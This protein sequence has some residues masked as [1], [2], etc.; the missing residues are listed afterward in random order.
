[1]GEGEGQ[2]NGDGGWV[3]APPRRARAWRGQR[4]HARLPCLSLTYIYAYISIYPCDISELLYNFAFSPSTTKEKM[5]F[6]SSSSLS[7]A[8]AAAA[9]SRTPNCPEPL[10]WGM[11]PLLRTYVRLFA[12][13]I[14]NRLAS[15]RGVKESYVLQPAGR[16]I[17]RVVVMG[18]IIAT[19]AK[20]KFI[21]YI[22]DDGTGWLTC[23]LWEKESMT[24]DPLQG[25]GW[26]RGRLNK[27]GKQRERTLLVYGDHAYAR[28]ELP[29]GTLVEVHGRLR[30]HCAPWN[31]WEG[32]K[33]E[34]EI[35]VDSLRPVEDCNEELWHWLECIRLWKECYSQPCPQIQAML[36]EQQEKQK[37]AQRQQWRQRHHW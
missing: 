35:S 10:V 30:S 9:S 18:H 36:Q 15:A 34:R 6:S 33:P 26:S 24:T 3:S 32:R 21:R 8:S 12:I 22:V 4:R 29:L 2:S 27:N 11:D 1:M 25:G 19:H 31:Q 20:E 5:E 37:R 7:S 13:D 17:T 14:H 28:Q 23:L 16:P